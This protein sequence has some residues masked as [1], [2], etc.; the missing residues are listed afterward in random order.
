MN[1]RRV[2]RAFALLAWLLAA[3]LAGRPA[4]LAAAEATEITMWSNWPDEPAKKAWVSA[5]VQ[6]FETAHPDCTVKLSFIPKA[7]IY[8]QATSAVRTGQAPDIFYMEPDQPQFLA[9]GF[10]E[11]LDA[12]IDV[13]NGVEDWAKPA[14]TSKG[15]LYGLPVEAYT[16]E[17]YYNRALLQKLGIAVPPSFQMTQAEFAALVQKGVAAGIT[18]VA[19]GVGDRPFPGGFLLFESLL[20]KLGPEDYG[21][22][23]N[24]GLSF[25]DPRV[26]EVMTW[27]KGLVD[28][29][30]YPKSFSTLKLGESHFYFYNTP[31]AL[32]FPDP[33][34]FTGRAFASPE[35]GGMPADFPLG[36]M[37]FPAMES[38]NCP[39]CKTLAVG[40]SFVIYAKSQHKACAGALLN[41][42]ATVE[43]GTKWMEQVALQTGIRSDPSK[44]V[45]PH[46]SYFTELNARDKG[47]RYFFGTP[48]LYYRGKCAD[49][50]AQVM[51]NAFP[52]GLLSVAEAADKMDAACFKG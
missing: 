47:A 19:Q 44:I 17:L 49:T 1:H 45:S 43:N 41:S 9:G 25:K 33:S 27:V 35:T 5:R 36:I 6:A 31:G 39:E 11:P 46:A 10:L 52:A 28:A 37:Q 48:L 15:K 3:I 23:L 38:G 14:W 40:G 21:K 12:Y 34:W 32:T 20:R 8:T 51:N 29:G 18:P 16:V 30:A 22:L 50:Y 2:S 24:G 13:A 26:T 42:M 7:D 4:P